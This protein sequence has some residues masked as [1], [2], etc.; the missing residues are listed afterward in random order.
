MQSTFQE[1][2]NIYTRI[3]Q[4]LECQPSNFQA[5]SFWVLNNKEHKIKW[6]CTALRKKEAGISCL[7]SETNLEDKLILFPSSISVELQFISSRTWS[8]KL[9]EVRESMWES[10]FVIMDLVCNAGQQITTENNCSARPVQNK[11]SMKLQCSFLQASQ[12]GEILLCNF[13]G[14]GKSNC[15]NIVLKIKSKLKTFSS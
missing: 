10:S 7:K 2:F 3:V 12:Q 15:C 14:I 4:E 8:E 11:I 1:C 5:H 6:A 9:W 13:I